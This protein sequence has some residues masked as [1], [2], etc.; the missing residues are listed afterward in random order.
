MVGGHFK[1]EVN[2]FS[3]FIFVQHMYDIDTSDN[4]VFMLQNLLDK[5]KEELRPARDAINQ[6]LR[7]AGFSF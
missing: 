2:I 5:M 6:T 7:C 3:I 1:L 4:G